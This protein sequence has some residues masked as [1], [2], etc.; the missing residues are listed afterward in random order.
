[1]AVKVAVGTITVGGRL[2]VVSVNVA[3]GVNVAVA[4]TEGVNV[5]VGG[6]GVGVGMV[7]VAVGI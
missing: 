1:M 2:P 6:S 5:A 4:V 7:G 3:D